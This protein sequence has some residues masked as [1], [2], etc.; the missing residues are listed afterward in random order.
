[1]STLIRRHHCHRPVHADATQISRRRCRPCVVSLNLIFRH[2]GLAL[3]GPAH[4]PRWCERH[5]LT[6]MICRLSGAFAAAIAFRHQRPVAP[7]ASTPAGWYRAG[8]ERQIAT[9]GARLR[10]NASGS[11]RRPPVASGL[12]G[13]H[14]VAAATANIE[15]SRPSAACRS[16]ISNSSYCRSTFILRR[17]D[18]RRRSLVCRDDRSPAPRS[19]CDRAAG[20]DRKTALSAPIVIALITC[21]SRRPGRPPL[22]WPRGSWLRQIRDVAPVR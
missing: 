11:P 22:L 5:W 9:T 16:R 1:M 4:A 10:H 18:R 20:A 7:S 3:R 19:I 6:A 21:I 8:T 2:E 15:G 12:T 14:G 17:A 13:I